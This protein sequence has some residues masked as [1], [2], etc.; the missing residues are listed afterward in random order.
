VF[1]IIVNFLIEEQN[2]DIV[3]D[4]NR[5][6]SSYHNSFGRKIERLYFSSKYL[7]FFLKISDFIS[8]A[9]P[10]LIGSRDAIDIGILS[11]IKLV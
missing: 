8:V 3:D 7:I 9:F 6:T 10:E 11:W 1:I 5:N 4:D 2:E